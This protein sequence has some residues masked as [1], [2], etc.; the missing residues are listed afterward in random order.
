MISLCGC[1]LQNSSPSIARTF[2]QKALEDVATARFRSFFPRLL[3]CSRAFFLPLF[4]LP[5]P[6]KG[7][8]RSMYA[9]T[10]A[11]IP[12]SAANT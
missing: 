6:I 11:D 10:A 1:T 7:L 2:L 4:G 3:A 8:L 5:T 12:F 9:T